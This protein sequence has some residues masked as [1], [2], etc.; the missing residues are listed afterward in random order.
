MGNNKFK[1]VDKQKLIEFVNF[2]AEKSTFNELKVQ[3]VIK[4]YGLL[5]FI[6]KE[7]IPKVQANTLELGKV[8]ENETPPPISNIKEDN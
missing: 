1:E 4:F 3:D 7:L 6:Q 5:S 2:V 8:T